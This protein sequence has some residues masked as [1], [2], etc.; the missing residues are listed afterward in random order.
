MIRCQRFV[1]PPVLI[2]RLV[3]RVAAIP[4]FA[5]SV[6]LL[7]ALALGL[8]PARASAGAATVREYK[9]TFRTYPFSDPD[10]IPRA[11]RIYPYFRIDGFTDRPVD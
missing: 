10:P 5:V 11:G 3:V 6:V 4:R 1:V 8:L 9:K 7:A 2:Q